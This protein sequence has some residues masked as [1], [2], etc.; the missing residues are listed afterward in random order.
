MTERTVKEVHN[1]LAQLMDEHFRN[2][3]TET[4]IAMSTE[5]T[6]QHGERLQQ[7]RKLLRDYLVVRR[8]DT[9]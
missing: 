2:L 5:Q 3:K 8:V 6:H 9:K 4:F 1:E 7:I